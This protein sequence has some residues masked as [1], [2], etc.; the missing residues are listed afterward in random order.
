MWLYSIYLVI[1]CSG[2]ITPGVITYIIHGIIT[3]IIHGPHIIYT[4]HYIAGYPTCFSTVGCP[5]YSYIAG[6]F[7]GGGRWLR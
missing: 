4:I 1:K 2:G 6:P 5:T 7:S 3:I